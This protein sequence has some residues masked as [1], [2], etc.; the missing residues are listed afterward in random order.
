MK[1]IIIIVCL[2][3]PYTIFA[4][5]KEDHSKDTKPQ[6]QT[7]VSNKQK[8]ILNY[9]NINNEYKEKV[10][11]IFRKKCFDCHGIIKKLPWYYKLPLIKQLIDYDIKEAKKHLDMTDDFPFGGHGNPLADME[12]IRKTAVKKSMPPWRYLIMHL[13]YRLTDQ[14]TEDIIN[15]INSAKKQL[16]S[17]TTKK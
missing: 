11:Q 5:G 1:S 9:L 14:N 3:I 13:D 4:H 12:S 8:S 2:L 6:L 16:H 7:V 17:L 15:W 10:K